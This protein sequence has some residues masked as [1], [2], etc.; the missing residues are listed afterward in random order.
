MHLLTDSRKLTQAESSLFFAIVSERNDG[1]RYIDELYHKGVRNFVISLQYSF[2]LTLKGC[3]VIAVEDTLQAMQLLAVQHRK[4]F[5]IPVAAITGSNGKT[6]VKEWL[7]QLLRDEFRV[8]RSPKSYNSQI[9]VPLSVWQM[10]PEHT[11]GIFEAGISKAGEMENLARILRPNVGVFTNLGSAHDEGFHSREEKLN[12]KFKLFADCDVLIYSKDDADV[13]N[14]AH[15]FFE[16]YP[17]TKGISWS[18]HDRGTITAKQIQKDAYGTSVSF[19]YRA[20]TFQFRIPFTDNASV[21]NA[22]ACVCF[23]LA[24]ERLSPETLERFSTLQPVE[25]RLQLRE[26]NRNCTIINDTYNSDIQSLRIALDFLNQQNQ[27]K[28]KTI[29]LSD[30]LESGSNLDELYKQVANMVEQAGVQRIIGV[31]KDICQQFQKFNI[32]KKFFFNTAHFLENFNS[33]T[34]QDEII[35][36]KGAR[37]FEFEKITRLLENKI[38]ATVM[39]INL[40]ALVNNLN[41]YRNN[42]YPGTKVMA[43]V[44]AYSYGSGSHEIAKTLEYHRVDYLTVAY[45]DEGVTLR[46]AGVK[47]PIMVMNPEPGSFLNLAEYNL[48]PE[49]YNRY[50]LDDLINHVEGA[51]TGIHLELDTGMRRLGFDE[52]ELNDVL[53]V[54]K[55]NKN[56]IVKSVFSHLAASDEQEHDLFTW[57]QIERFEHMSRYV[58]QS[59]GYPILRHVLNSSG[60]TRFHEAQFDMVR[61]G[62]G[63][64]GIDPSGSYLDKLE[65]VGTL[66]TIISQLRQVKAGESVGYSRKGKVQQ[67][68]TIAVVAIGYADGLDRGLS[69]GN[70]FMLVNGKPAPIVGNICM[71][72]TMLDVTHIPCQE[73]DEVLVFGKQLPITELASRINTIPYE[74]LTGIS[75]RVRRVYYQE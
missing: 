1:H 22:L 57:E 31:G 45:A 2:P 30:I 39:E 15:E 53:D 4:R 32:S 68:A 27:H 8:V 73:G 46:K 18:M 59:L 75:Q 24:V 33:F 25:M 67:N 5:S 42:L 52:H 37:S 23:L 62:I 74:I 61:L 11:L 66:K 13:K 28:Q 41:V 34:F 54:L 65:Q 69:N 7:Y 51:E 72:M 55:K 64:Y 71:D 3:S 48:E 40:N 44:K 49:I 12:E 29:I 14:K 6:I 47:T 70:G 19:E 56:L 63:L 20:T 58:I 43:M 21:Q 16:Q 9:G 36:I 17:M 38:H 10:Q 35:L 50:I 26:G 60:I